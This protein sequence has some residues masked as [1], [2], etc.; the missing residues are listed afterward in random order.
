MT[1]LIAL[2]AA[3]IDIPSVSRDEAAVVAFIEAEL[4]G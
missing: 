1:D 3:L 2:T 4:G